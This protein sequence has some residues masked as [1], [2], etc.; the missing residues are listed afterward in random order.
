MKMKEW[1]EGSGIYKVSARQLPDTAW[2]VRDTN[3][4]Q[5]GEFAPLL[6]ICEKDLDPAAVKEPTYVIMTEEVIWDGYN[7]WYY[8]KGCKQKWQTEEELRAVWEDGLGT[9]YEAQA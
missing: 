8:C 5:E 4:V 6:H 7:G 2:F 9:G 1:I 3:L